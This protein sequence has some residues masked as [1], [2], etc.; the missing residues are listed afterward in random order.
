VNEFTA[1]QNV[2]L[3]G[4][5]QLKVEL[6]PGHAVPAG[7]HVVLVPEPHGVVPAAQPQKPLALSRQATPALQHLDPHGVVPAGQQQPVLPKEVEQVA[8]AGQQKPPHFWRPSGQV[9]TV[10]VGAGAAVAAPNGFSTVAP[11]AAAAAAPKTPS[12]CRLVD[13]FARLRVSRS[14][15]W[16]ERL[17]AG[18]SGRSG[19]T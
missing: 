8:L 15:D 6:T 13:V 12:A 2:A 1:V 17:G 9:P 16:P 19:S 10:V 18:T 5:G 3:F 4:G 11:T 7:Q 14:N